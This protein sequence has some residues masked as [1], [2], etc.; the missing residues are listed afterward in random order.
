MAKEP[1]LILRDTNDENY[2]ELVIYENNKPPKIYDV[3]L[4]RLLIW[5]NV[6]GTYFSKIL[7]KLL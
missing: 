6:I 1:L 2:L 3:P 5:Q 7:S 4:K